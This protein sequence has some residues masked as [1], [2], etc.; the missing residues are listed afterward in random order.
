MLRVQG[1]AGWDVQRTQ[2]CSGWLPRPPQFPRPPPAG[3]AGSTFWVRCF[4]S[5]EAP[6]GSAASCPLHCSPT[7]AGLATVSADR[8][9]RGTAAPSVAAA[10]RGHM[11]R[12]RPSRERTPGGKRPREMGLA[13]LLSLL[14]ALGLRIVPTWLWVWVGEPVPPRLPAPPSAAWILPSRAW[15]RLS[16]TPQPRRSP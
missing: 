2:P 8:G 16:W 3:P 11:G 6:S 5:R 7:R 10:P 4:L 14:P 13:L 12:V 1:A 9:T 15:A